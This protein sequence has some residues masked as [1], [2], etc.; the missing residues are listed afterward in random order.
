M[1]RSAGAFRL[2]HRKADRGMRS[3]LHEGEL[4]HAGDEDE[5]R[6]EGIGR[7]RL[8]EKAAEHV[9]DLAQPAQA[10]CRDSAGERAVAKCKA[11]KGGFRARCREGFVERLP[12]SQH[13]LQKMRGELAGLL[14]RSL[15]LHVGIAPSSRETPTALCGIA[16]RTKLTFG[17]IPDSRKRLSG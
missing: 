13:R 1:P 3:D 17:K 7:Q 11:G 10:G 9:F 8:F 14:P 16:K 5:T 2:L 6:L 15:R 12:V 4:R